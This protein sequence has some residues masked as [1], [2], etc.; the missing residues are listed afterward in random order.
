MGGNT[1]INRRHIEID[2]YIQ[3]GPALVYHNNDPGIV[4][5]D[6][7][8]V[9]ER[10]FFVQICCRRFDVLRWDGLSYETAILTAEKLAREHG[11][12]VLDKVGGAE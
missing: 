11:C 2:T 10:R 5:V 1:R 8:I 12:A 3:E 6:W 9:G 4:H 7:S